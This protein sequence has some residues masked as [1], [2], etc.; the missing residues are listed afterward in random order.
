MRP[1][2]FVHAADLHLD[3]PFKG[4]EEI[5]P[6]IAEHL[7]EATFKAFK[8]IVDLC[9]EREA[10]FLLI[11]GD[12]FDGKDRSLRAQIRFRDELIRLTQAGIASYIINGN[13]DP[14]DSWLD[15][16]TWP[17]Q[18]HFFGSGQVEQK[19]VQDDSDLLAV[20]YGTSY[21]HREVRNNLARG[22]R[23]NAGDPFAIGLLHANVGGDSTHESYAPC[24][25]EDLQEA[26]MDYWAL[27]HIHKWAVLHEAEPVVVYA[28]NPQGRD[29]G[30]SGAHGCIVVD[31]DSDGRPSLEFVPTDLVRWAH[32]Q[33]SI[34][35]L[36]GEE[37]LTEVLE[38]QCLENAVEG[39]GNRQSGRRRAPGTE[40]CP[41]NT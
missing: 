17:E 37:E 5:T 11:A 35:S 38:E 2:R 26:G 32:G 4:I 34:D 8:N 39:R 14:R 25:L 21:E 13:H 20:I 23:R 41:E 36:E 22:Y 29:P 33:V 10:D 28:G 27:G 24:S 15:K 31:V 19:G 30:E 3:S 9:I 18:V 12:V 6:K 40:G 7:R 16:L 1:F